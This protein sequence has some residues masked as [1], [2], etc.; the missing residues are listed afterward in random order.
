MLSAE[1]SIVNTMFD[2]QLV[3]AYILAAGALAG[4][5]MATVDSAG[6]SLR[7]ASFSA[8]TLITHVTLTTHLILQVVR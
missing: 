3:I 7:P 8:L 1:S 6:T 4:V 5:L 2:D